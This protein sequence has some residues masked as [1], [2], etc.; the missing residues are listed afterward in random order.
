M[1]QKEYKGKLLDVRKDRLDLRDRTYRPV[2]KSLAES[3]P[4]VT[5]IDEIIKCYRAD[6]L[7][8][9]QGEE[10]SCSGYALAAVINYLIWKKKILKDYKNFLENPLVVNSQQ[11][12]SKM[13]YNLARIYDEWDGEDYEGSSCRG[14]MKGWHKHGVCSKACWDNDMDEPQ[15]GWEKESIEKPLGAYYRVEKK[16]IN[17]MQSAL[18]EVG[19][20]YVSAVVHDGWWEL[21]DQDFHEIKDINSD[22]PH[23][24]YDA[25]P[26]GN[27]AFV[28]IG[29][30]RHGF[31]VQNSWG[32]RWGNCGF[33]VLTYK[34]WLA[35]S[36]DAWVA[37][38]G[39]PVEMGGTSTAFSNLSLSSVNNE[40]VEGTKTIK[41]AL[42][43]PYP[44]ISKP[45]S[46]EEAYKHT[47]VLNSHGRA[48]HTMVY[49]TKLER[50]I[51]IICYEQLKKWLDRCDE[52]KKVALY[53][54][55]GLE[56][57]KEYMS[58]IR[59]LIPY[60]LHNGIYPIFLTWQ[61]SYL[62]AIKKS[63]D[64]F[65]Q[66]SMENKILDISDETILQ[67]KEALN[68][69]IENHSKNISTRAIWG[70]IKEKSIN[71]NQKKI[72]GFEEKEP[73]S[74]ALYILTNYLE[75]LIREEEYE[76][77]IHAIAHSAGSQ[78]LATT[79][80]RELAKRKLKLNSMH[81]LAPT[82]SIQECNIHMRYAFKKEV[83][84][85]KNIHIYMLT[86]EMELADR[87]GPYSK[88]ILYLISRSLDKIHKTPLLGLQDSWILE[89]SKSEDGIFNTRQ[90]SEIKKWY[91]F[92]LEEKEPYSLFFLTKEDIKLQCS[93]NNDYV[94]LSHKNLDKS[95]L[96]L[97]R[98]LKLISTGS[99]D[100]ELKCPVENLC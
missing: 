42:S 85:K 12:S 36:L 81:L 33:A 100:A 91:K 58:K 32:Q 7:V 47:L 97:E 14:A 48:K 71:A 17:D 92:A 9:D 1:G 94:K 64:T 18:C 80:L 70:E 41:K 89:N 22:I 8:L 16:S 88:S 93:K 19:A 84:E 76:F 25:F 73:I 52:H 39:V 20:L 46:E 37:V 27:H 23:I 50:S 98:I 10:G 26:K 11:V 31:I 69:A 65:F 72:Y 30:T 56:D 21:L 63:I 6:E 55:G 45:K 57:E 40:Q 87:V 34:D 82:V 79:W 44:I 59:V 75:K 60:F 74:G 61:Y 51:E 99:V 86:K 49:V 43:Y 3:Y 78:L 83:F 13:L 28:I 62:E 4:N 77:E 96:I 53:A 38:M 15:E 66:E 68:R 67:E 24:P 95:V 29:Y 2:L 35:N 54:L 5:D 90:L